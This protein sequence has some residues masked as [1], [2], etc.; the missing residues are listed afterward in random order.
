M[1]VY[2]FIVLA[3]S[4]LRPHLS[5]GSSS[6]A[7]GLTRVGLLPLPSS[8]RNAFEAKPVPS[9]RNAFEA[10]PLTN[11]Q[12]IGSQQALT[13][14]LP[15]S[16]TRP[17]M[18]L[19][20]GIRPPIPFLTSNGNGSHFRGVYP[21]AGTPAA[22]GSGINGNFGG[23][24]GGF[25]DG[26]GMGRVVNGDRLF[27]PSSGPHATAASTSHFNGGG[28]DPLHRNGM[29]EDRSSETDETLVY[30][31]VLQVFLSLSHLLASVVLILFYC[32]VGFNTMSERLTCFLGFGCLNI[33]K[34]LEIEQHADSLSFR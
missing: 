6:N 15:P 16:L 33:P 3:G 26:I 4:T 19:R 17:P 11:G 2:V 20:P 31:A 12:H 13:R 8:S 14:V 7:N 25:H 23:G 29:G 22:S 9:S 24:Y 1:C 30:Q 21:P 32:S 10:K 5:I 28:G 34:V 18:P 27:P